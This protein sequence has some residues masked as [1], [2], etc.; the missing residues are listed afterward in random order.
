MRITH[1]KKKVLRL[2][3]SGNHMQLG[4]V[5]KSE[6][7]V[8][9]F[10]YFNSLRLFLLHAREQTKWLVHSNLNP[11]EDRYVLKQTEFLPDFVIVKG[12]LCFLSTVV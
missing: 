7:H 12:T 3:L 1:G 2:F 11:D 4:C 10:F 8:F 5:F 6:K 9:F